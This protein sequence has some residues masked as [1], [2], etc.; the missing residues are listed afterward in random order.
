M[1]WIQLEPI[2]FLGFTN[3]LQKSGNFCYH[4]NMRKFFQPTRRKIII[5]VVL[6]ILLYIFCLLFL[7]INLQPLC[8]PTLPN[9]GHPTEVINPA[10]TIAAWWF[11]LQLFM[12]IYWG[13][14]NYGI[15]CLSYAPRIY[16]MYQTITVIYLRLFPILAIILPYIISCEILALQT[17][18]KKK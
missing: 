13:I 17:K 5:T 16:S 11:A 15:W 7:R 12:Y 10:S 8:M 9:P 6:W 18:L 2:A 4:E 3:H 1:L 14:G